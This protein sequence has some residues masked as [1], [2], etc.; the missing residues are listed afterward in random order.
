MKNKRENEK[1][2]ERTY[3]SG[4]NISPYTTKTIMLTHVGLQ[5]APPRCSSSFSFSLRNKSKYLTSGTLKFW[6]E[7]QTPPKGS[8]L[9]RGFSSKSSFITK[10]FFPT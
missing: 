7:I 2:N 3:K 1:D 9:L 8:H 5:T 6:D 4:H 10:Y